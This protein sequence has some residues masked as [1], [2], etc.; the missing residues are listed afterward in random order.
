[1]GIYDLPW[2]FFALSPLFF[3]ALLSFLHALHVL[4]FLPS[5][6]LVLCPAAV[7]GG[8]G[9]SPAVAAVAAAVGG[10]VSR[11]SGVCCHP[12]VFCLGWWLVTVV[13]VGV[14]IALLDAVG[15][16]T[17]YFAFRCYRFGW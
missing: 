1:M 5:L 2:V 15:D 6:L 3:L 11:S 10:G 8:V 17:K 4:S 12:T 9:A 16:D 14:T 13:V 7:D